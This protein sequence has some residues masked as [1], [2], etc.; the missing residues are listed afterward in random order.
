MQDPLRGASQG[1]SGSGGSSG[2]GFEIG[3]PSAY[4]DSFPDVPEGDDDDGE[5]QTSDTTQAEPVDEV[6]T[7]VTVPN[8]YDRPSCAGGATCSR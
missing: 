1:S 3:D 7:T 5:S 2:A 4:P 6:G 8:T